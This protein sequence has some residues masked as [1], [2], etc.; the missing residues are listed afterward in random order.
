MTTKS[1]KHKKCPEHKILNPQTNRCVSRTGKIG[2][3]ILQLQ[4]SKHSSNKRTQ[5]SKHTSNKRRTPEKKIK[6]KKIKEKKIKEKK[7]NSETKNLRPYAQVVQ[8][9]LRN[10]KISSIPGILNMFANYLGGRLEHNNNVILFEKKMKKVKKKINEE[11]KK[12]KKDK[13]DKKLE[14]NIQRLFRDIDEIKLNINKEKF[15]SSINNETYEIIQFFEYVMNKDK[16]IFGTHFFRY[17]RFPP[18]INTDKKEVLLIQP[19]SAINNELKFYRFS[20]KNKNE[21]TIKQ[22]MRHPAYYYRGG[23]H[24]SLLIHE[25][26]DRFRDLPKLSNENVNILF[27]HEDIG[28][29]QF[30]LVSTIAKAYGFK[31][32]ED[33]IKYWRGKGVIYD[34][35]DDDSWEDYYL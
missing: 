8:D 21:N 32:I 11:K 7:I 17:A 5:E 25:I 19:A 4:E 18:M 12:Y 2:K 27:V 26:E 13:K 29:R 23:F 6:E 33:V 34:Y 16:K 28:S 1:K 14:K 31:F 24:V 30:Q 20:Y 22:L 9:V 3:A 15:L 35:D 10:N